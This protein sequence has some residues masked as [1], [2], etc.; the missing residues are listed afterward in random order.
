MEFFRNLFKAKEEEEDLPRSKPTK[1]HCIRFMTE[2]GEQLGMLLT[3][4]EFDIAVH[5]W[6]QNV[7]TMP[8]DE[9][10]DKEDAL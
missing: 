3:H 7:S 4:E 5:R 10:T 9:E 1:Y 8:I 2:K 6:V